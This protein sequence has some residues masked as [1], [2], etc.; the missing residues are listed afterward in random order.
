MKKPLYYLSLFLI[1][2]LCA[3][4]SSNEIIEP[5]PEFYYGDK[6]ENV[7]DPAYGFIP[8]NWH[9]GPD[10]AR[11]EKLNISKEFLASLSTMDL[12]RV[13]LTYPYLKDFV[14]CNTVY[15]MQNMMN[16]KIEWFYGFELLRQREDAFECVLDYYEGLIDE[17]NRLN[18]VR[19]FSVFQLPTCEFYIGSGQVYP[20][21]KL[22]GNERLE[23]LAIRALRIRENYSTYG[24]C[25]SMCGL[26]RILTV[27][28]FQFDFGPSHH[29]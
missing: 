28:G 3:C 24:G 15:Q 4:D 12:L 22:A 7:W 25:V 8:D 6:V 13:C 18:G 21:E 29:W 23:E 1:F 11:M 16:W 5:E 17:I 9:E 10:E 19:E 2:T 14:F 20:I 27:G 26:H